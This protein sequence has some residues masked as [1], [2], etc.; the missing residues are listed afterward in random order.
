MIRI[1]AAI[2]IYAICIGVPL[3]AYHCGTRMVQEGEDDGRE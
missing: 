2:A 3:V 1:I